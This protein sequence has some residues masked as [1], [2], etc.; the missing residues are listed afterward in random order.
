MPTN[1]CRCTVRLTVLAALLVIGVV[2]AGNGRALADSAD[3]LAPDPVEALRHRAAASLKKA[4]RFFAEQVATEGG[5]LW[6]YSA[7]L[8]RREGEGKASETTVW[9]QPP[10][11][12]SVG[13][14][15]L[16]LYHDTGDEDYLTWAMRAG[17]CLVRGQLVSGGWQYRIDFDPKQRAR[18]A[19]RVDSAEAGAGQR[20]NTVLDDNTTQAALRLLMRLDKTIGFKDSTIHEAAQYALERLIAAQYPNGAWPQCFWGPPEGDHYPVIP[21]S[22]PDHWPRKYPG[23]DYWLYYTFNDGAMC[24]VIDVLLEAWHVYGDERYRAAAARGGQFILLAQ[25]PDPQPAWA[26]QY[27]FQMHPVWARKFEPPAV[28]GGESQTVMRTLLQLYRET[29]QREYLEPIPRAVEYLRRS[30]LPNG[31]LA[32]F[33]ELQTNRPLYFTKQY[34]LTYSD[35]DVPTHYGFKVVSDVDRIWRDYR[36]LAALGPEELAKLRARPAAAPKVTGSLVARTEE[37]IAAL[38]DAGRWV[39]PGRLRSFGPDDPTR[40]VIDCGTF[41]RNVHVLGTFLRAASGRREGE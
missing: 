29:G 27:D 14:A 23:G 13:M 11:T 31:Q 30:T 22:Y 18:Y 35:A 16:Q 4:C 20:N 3:R 39:E 40:Q 38:D 10:G 5:Y 12:P 17:L 19:F 41:I 1:Q 15:L 8:S 36:D 6:R 34:E 33:Y 24:D 26:Q 2:P 7:D 37:V 28:T 32:R 25:M 21:A 9:V